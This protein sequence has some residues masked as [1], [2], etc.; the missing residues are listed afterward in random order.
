MTEVPRQAATY[1]IYEMTDLYIF[2]LLCRAQQY[3]TPLL[4]MPE[5]P[6]IKGI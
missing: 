5:G 2:L 4:S 3:L 1:L 6:F